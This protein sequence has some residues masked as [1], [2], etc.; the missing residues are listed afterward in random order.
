MGPPSPTE[1]VF[2]EGRD[3][4]VTEN[5]YSA[6]LRFRSPY[7]SVNPCVDAL[8][9][10]QDDIQKRNHQVKRMG[11]IYENSAVTLIWLGDYVECQEIMLR[12]TMGACSMGRGRCHACTGLAHVFDTCDCR[13]AKA[14]FDAKVSLLYFLKELVQL[15]VGTT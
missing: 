2:I 14:T 8:Y 10:N 3:F 5:L 11:R 6:L 13:E 7:F 1:T 15:C 4:E 12:V 9:L